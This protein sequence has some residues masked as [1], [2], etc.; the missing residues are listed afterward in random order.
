MEVPGA[1]T[2]VFTGIFGV[3][4]PSV[5]VVL[6]IAFTVSARLARYCCAASCDSTVCRPLVEAPWI[7]LARSAFEVRKR[8]IGPTVSY[9]CCVVAM[10]SEIKPP[11]INV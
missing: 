1:N 10:R 9:V 2:G 4:M 5:E 7:W 6:A 11:E 8:S 3:V